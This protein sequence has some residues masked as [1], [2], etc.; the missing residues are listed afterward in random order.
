MR[1]FKKLRVFL[2]AVVT[3]QLGGAV[4]L[5]M[6]G[7]HQGIALAQYI[8]VDVNIPMLP[9]FVRVYELD[10]LPERTALVLVSVPGLQG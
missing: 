10:E 9:V 2:C 1:V 7:N 4:F 5:R 8:L 3:Q 6:V